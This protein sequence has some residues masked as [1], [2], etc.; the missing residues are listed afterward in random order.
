MAPLLDSCFIDTSLCR[1]A[2]L[3]PF[4]KMS[5]NNALIDAADMP[6]LFLGDAS[7]PQATVNVKRIEIMLYRH[8][9][10]Q[11]PPFK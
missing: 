5:E 4:Y 8:H 11:S 6:G 10:G 1:S 9:H 2:S 3:L 7:I